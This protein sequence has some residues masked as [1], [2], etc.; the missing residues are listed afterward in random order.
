MEK[1]TITYSLKEKYKQLSYG[2]KNLIRRK[3][4]HWFNRKPAAFYQ[5]INGDLKMC[6]A[7]QEF[8]TQIITQ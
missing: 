1:S 6:P 3:Y 5:K 2:K 7:E 8:L 4:M